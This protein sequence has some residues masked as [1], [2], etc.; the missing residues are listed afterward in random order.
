MVKKIQVVCVICG[1]DTFGGVGKGQ[2]D[3][4]DRGLTMKGLTCHFY[5][6][7]IE[8]SETNQ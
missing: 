2:P 5:T 3:Q 6:D 1:L 8:K 7:E 4:V